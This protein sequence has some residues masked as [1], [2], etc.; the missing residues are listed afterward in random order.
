VLALPPEWKLEQLSVTPPPPDLEEWYRP[1]R[2]LKMLARLPHEYET[3]LGFGHTVP[4]GDP[5]ERFVEATRMRGWIVL[6]LL[7]VPEEACTLVLA[8]GR[9][10]NFYAVHALY[11]EEMSL[12]L[13]KGT[14]ALLDAFEA[15]DISEVLQPDRCPC[16]KRKLF[17]LF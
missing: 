14:D 3:W 8:D 15:A 6:P 7:S 9:L 2:W 17:G 5:P 12:K 13:N 16:V 4:N 11:P 10:V 1:V